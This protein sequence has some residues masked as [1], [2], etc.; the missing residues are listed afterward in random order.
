[1]GDVAPPT[2]I[3]ARHFDYL[4]RYVQ[5]GLAG[6][7]V[8]SLSFPTEVDASVD[9]D[10]ELLD[11][12]DAYLAGNPDDFTD[13]SVA[14]T[15]RTDHREVLQTVREVPYG[16]N[17]DVSTIAR[18]AP[19]LSDDDAG[20]RSVR[21]ALADNPVPLL[22]PDHRVRDGPSGAPPE[23]ELKLRSLEGL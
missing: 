7:R 18:M 1:M 12:I 20:S 13:V 10:H 5:L 19:G 16:T 11:R 17:V 21:E 4:G 15:L 6:G 23:I 9:S 3:F 14:L 22:I 8:I 2:G